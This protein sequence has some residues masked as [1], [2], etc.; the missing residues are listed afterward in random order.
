[1][2]HSKFVLSKTDCW[3][4]SVKNKSP[5]IVWTVTISERHVCFGEY[6]KQTEKKQKKKGKQNDL[7]NKKIKYIDSNN[8][9]SNS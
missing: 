2:Y 5:L 3:I 6:K 1:M 8:N 7:H 9:L 4:G